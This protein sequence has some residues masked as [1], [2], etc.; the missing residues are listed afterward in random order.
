M[1]LTPEELDRRRQ[2]ITAT[3]V[4]AILGLSPWRNAADVY[5]TKVRGTDQPTNDAMQAGHLLEPSVI[6]WAE[7]RLGRINPGDWK[8]AENG[9]NAAS[10]DGELADG[11]DVVEAK[12][13]GITGPGSPGQW[14]EQMTDEI[15]DY[16]L[17]QVQT[18]LLVTGKP[19]A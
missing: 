15:P 14:G 17:L 11:G 12:T 2:F 13:S 7:T 6:R 10:L 5:W 8:V 4:P 1:S 16:Y 3:D 19:V 9:I 18:Q